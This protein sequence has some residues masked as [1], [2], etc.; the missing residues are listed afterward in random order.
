MLDLNKVEYLGEHL[1][2]ITHELLLEI[3]GQKY[4]VQGYHQILS[5]IFSRYFLADLSQEKFLVIKEAP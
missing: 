1:K 2:Y 4:C 5:D 3:Q